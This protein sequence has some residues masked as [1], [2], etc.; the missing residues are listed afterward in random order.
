MIQISTKRPLAEEDLVGQLPL[1]KQDLQAVIDIM[2]SIPEKK[3]APAHLQSDRGASKTA[4]FSKTFCIKF[5]SSRSIASECTVYNEFQSRGLSEILVPTVFLELDKK[6]YSP[7]GAI[8]ECG[9]D[10]SVIQPFVEIFTKS[11]FPHTTSKIPSEIERIIRDLYIE[12]IAPPRWSE[13]VYDFYGHDFF[14]KF[15]EA[16]QEL[17]IW[18]LHSKNVGYLGSRP[19]ILDWDL[20]VYT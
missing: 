7:F 18:D 11:D 14:I 5:S 4:F 9:V 15:I 10:Y 12:R 6:S 1:S 3:R 2:N 16:I 13:N 17:E 20:N 8:A 19:V